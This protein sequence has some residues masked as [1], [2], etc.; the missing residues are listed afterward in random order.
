MRDWE[1]DIFLKIY[2]GYDGTGTR[3]KLD[4]RT[5]ICKKCTFFVQDTLPADHGQHR[6]LGKL[7]VIMFSHPVRV[8]SGNGSEE[9][10]VGLVGFLKS[11]Y[12]YVLRSDSYPLLLSFLLKIELLSTFY[13]NF[14]NLNFVICNP[15][16][17]NK[18]NM[19]C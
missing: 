17:F 12:L 1:P 15:I 9:I 4:K 10:F 6:G 8:R 7:N 11:N 16:S 13:F 18:K 19:Y 5:N 2:F 14:K 3:S